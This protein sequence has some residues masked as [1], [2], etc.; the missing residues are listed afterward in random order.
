MKVNIILLLFKCHLIIT[1]V[2]ILL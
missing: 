2:N 1:H